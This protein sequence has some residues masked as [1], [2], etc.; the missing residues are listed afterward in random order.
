MGLYDKLECND[1]FDKVIELIPEE[2]YRWL[3]DTLERMKKDA[4][5]YKNTAAAVLRGII[6]DL[7]KNAAEAAEIM[8]SFDPEKYKAVADF[9]IA[10]NGGRNLK[11]NQ[12]V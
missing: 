6:Q 9:A 4:L 2:E 12:P 7:P 5:A 3:F 1:I 8:N 11:T 10:A